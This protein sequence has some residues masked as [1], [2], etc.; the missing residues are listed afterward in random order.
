[1][2]LAR[3]LLAVWLALA[4]AS[5]SSAVEQ[6]I[7][8]NYGCFQRATA[9]FDDADLEALRTWVHAAT[10]AAGERALLAQAIGRM[11]AIA[12]GQTPIWRDRGRNSMEERGLDGAMDCID[13]SINTEAFLRVLAGAGA[14]RFHVPGERRRRFAFLVFGEHWT[15][16][17]IETQSQ[18]RFAVD[19]WFHD[20]GLPVTVV[21][22]ERWR[23]GYDPEAE[24]QAA[25]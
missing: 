18:S 10:D 16:T 7:C 12:A 21:A 6:E 20:P 1:M 5:A 14:L 17:L 22:L 2:T 25:R 9:R 4:T 19:S 13:H 8:Y 11:Y 23:A 3:S 15:A 24:M